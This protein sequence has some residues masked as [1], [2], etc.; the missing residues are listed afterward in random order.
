MATP[1]ASTSGTTPASSKSRCFMS[2]APLLFLR[3]APQIVSLG[4]GRVKRR[5]DLE[6]VGLCRLPTRRWACGR[7]L[8]RGFLLPE[9]CQRDDREADARQEQRDPDDDG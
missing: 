4:T 2:P 7:S 9:H 1:I 6:V 8:R 3:P 5:L